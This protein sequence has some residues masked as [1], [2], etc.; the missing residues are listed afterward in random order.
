MEFV[1]TIVKK[2]SSH[3]KNFVSIANIKGL[4]HCSTC[5]TF[6]KKFLGD[7]KNYILLKVKCKKRKKEKE[8]YKNRVC[9]LYRNNERV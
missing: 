3:G 4:F 2:G 9:K 5:K 1:V 7:R 6:Q 8:I